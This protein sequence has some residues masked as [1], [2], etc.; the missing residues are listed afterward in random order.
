MSL[1]G[2]LWSPVSSIHGLLTGSS[3]AK[4]LDENQPSYNL[5]LELVSQ[6]VA[7]YGDDKKLLLK[8]SLVSR[9]WR[10]ACLPFIFRNTDLQ[11]STD[12]RRWNHII[13]SSPDIAR[14]VRRVQFC[15]TSSRN[16]DLLPPLGDSLKDI[17]PLSVMPGVTELA[18]T[19]F[20]G[21]REC[22]ISPTP[23]IIQFL[24]SFPALRRVE[25]YAQ[26]LDVR[27]LEYFLANCGPVKEL[28]LHNFTLQHEPYQNGSWNSP[29]SYHL[30]TSHLDLSSLEH[31]VIDGESFTSEWVV[32]SLFT[33]SRPEQL[34]ALTVTSLYRDLPLLKSLPLINLFA[35]S[36]EVLTVKTP[37]WTP[38]SGPDPALEPFPSLRILTVSTDTTHVPTSRQYTIEKFLRIVQAENLTTLE[39]RAPVVGESGEVI[40]AL[41][42]YN[43]K[44]LCGVISKRFPRLEAL[45]LWFM[46]DGRIPRRRR[47]K[48]LTKVKKRIPR[49]YLDGKE[50]RVRWSV[51]NEFAG[52]YD[53]DCDVESESDSGSELR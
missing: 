43:W 4:L 46:L 6:I 9:T 19:P 14:L 11:S 2:L 26:F 47:T 38:E 53:S 27:S 35:S 33:E 45:V 15:P 40:N 22:T 49:S 20:F 44:Q 28:A 21:H 1:S 34:R 41:G 31:L 48:L 36:L 16:S 13:E 24:Q 52:S 17:P 51:E 30:D 7:F 5:P 3:S 23:S 32:D 39:L 10:G 8:H 12:F 25:I 50:I 37:S 42:D 29:S 18:W